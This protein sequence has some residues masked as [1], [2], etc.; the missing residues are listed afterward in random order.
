MA[1]LQTGLRYQSN[2]LPLL[3]PDAGLISKF[4]APMCRWATAAP[5]KA[6]GNAFALVP[7]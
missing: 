5:Q 6:D 1:F 7:A 4:R 3:L 2:A